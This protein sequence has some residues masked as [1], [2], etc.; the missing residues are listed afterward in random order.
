MNRQSFT[1][2]A[3]KR[4]LS[5]SDKHSLANMGSRSCV[6]S[7]INDAIKI[8]DENFRSGISVNKIFV[9][10]NCV[11]SSSCLKEKL[12][13]RHCNSNLKTVRSLLPKQRNNIISE[14]KIYLKEGTVYRVYR[15]DIK[16]FFESIDLQVLLNKLH[17]EQSISMHTKNLIEWY[18]KGCERIHSSSGL[19]RGLEISPILSE[20]Y[21]SNFDKVINRHPNVIYYSRFVDDMIIISDGCE[22]DG[23][24]I[25]EVQ[26]VLPN[27]LR[28]NKNKLSISPLI[29]KRSCG[30]K[31]SRG[32]KLIYEFDF[33][34]YAFSI[35]D[36]YLEKA[37]AAQRVYR[38]VRVE[39]SKKR[40]KKIKTR[41]AKAFYSYHK[42]GDFKLLLDR[43]SFLTSNRDLSRKIKASDS[44]GKS[45]ISTG[46]YYSNS[47]I[48]GG[49]KSL[50]ELDDFLIFCV[51]SN[52][53]RFGK[54]NF[55][56]ITI[57]QKKE[58][59]RNSFKKGFL[60]RVY[61]AYN[62]NRYVEITKIWL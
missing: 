18:L 35:V 25:K 22:D 5:Q 21:L 13:L 32:D 54:I 19:P 40:I 43:I 42:N 7:L 1:T 12:I 15:L 4:C 50:E 49:T 39:L 20:L 41:V 28:L 62:F 46:V 61:R 38:T 26:G 14:L 29:P 57:N 33:L 9:K 6:D 30:D 10:G 16:S 8:A 45:K 17:N 11:Y 47:M 59:L 24:F 44:A 51:K 55:R 23:E 2:S 56:A 31:A 48:D 58:I 53:G 3:L 52:R 60:S 27:G 36:H 37:G 34:G